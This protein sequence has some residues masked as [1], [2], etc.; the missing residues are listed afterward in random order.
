[1]QQHRILQDEGRAW[2]Q[3]RGSRQV[4]TLAAPSCSGSGCLVDIGVFDTQRTWPTVADNTGWR[5]SRGR[6]A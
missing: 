1:M 6:E 4:P 3:D 2:V 5:E